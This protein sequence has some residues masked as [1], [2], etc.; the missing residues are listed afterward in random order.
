MQVSIVLVGRPTLANSD[1]PLT[2]PPEVQACRIHTLPLAETVRVQALNRGIQIRLARNPVIS[3][4]T[5]PAQ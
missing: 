2:D 5:K 1:H 4:F 3:V